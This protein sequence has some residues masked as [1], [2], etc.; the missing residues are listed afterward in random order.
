MGDLKYHKFVGW[1]ETGVL[2][3]DDWLVAS[4]RRMKLGELW[5]KNGPADEYW[6]CINTRTGGGK[7]P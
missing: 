2:D 1:M 7:C 4:A 6:R 5:A 3:R